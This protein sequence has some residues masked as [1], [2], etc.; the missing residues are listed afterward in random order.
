MKNKLK[1]KRLTGNFNDLSPGLVGH[2]VKQRFRE[3]RRNCR[4]TRM[5]SGFGGLS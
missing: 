5:L 2:I 4:S 1:E 3:P